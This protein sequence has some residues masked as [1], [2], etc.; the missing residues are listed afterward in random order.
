MAFE[1]LPHFQSSLLT[2]LSQILSASSAVTSDDARQHARSLLSLGLVELL[3][4]LT[5]QGQTA[6]FG[7]VEHKD[8]QGLLKSLDMEHFSPE[9]T[10][11]TRVDAEQFRIWHE[12]VLEKILEELKQFSD[13]ASLG[14]AGLAELINGQWEHLASIPQWM[15]NATQLS[16]TAARH[17]MVSHSESAP[18]DTEQQLQENMAGLM[19]LMKQAQHSS[20]ASQDVHHLHDHPE[21]ALPV[22]LQAPAWSKCVLPLLAVAVMI[23]LTWLYGQDLATAT[24]RPT[25]VYL[26]SSDKS[27]KPAEIR[28]SNTA[29][30]ISPAQESAHSP[31]DSA[32]SLAPTDPQAADHT[33]ESDDAVLRPVTPEDE[34][35]QE[36]PLEISSDVSKEH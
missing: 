36:L 13:I 10:A 35:T 12:I 16:S 20:I 14:E 30:V 9:M 15:W 26:M 5:H 17:S 27:A 19:Q 28:P 11:P 25:P 34:S 29:P 21:I 18:M 2:P 32:P 3:A 22:F 23:G 31:A 8:A 33:K 24:E 1:L 7:F 6:L 4:V